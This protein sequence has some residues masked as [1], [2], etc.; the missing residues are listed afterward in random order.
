[1]I[2]CAN[3][4][5]Q[6]LA[7]KEEIDEAVKRV[8]EGDRYILGDEVAE[9]EK[10]F[11]A[12]IETKTCIGVANGTDALHLALRAVGVKY[13]DEVITTAHT[14]VA[15]ASAIVLAGAIP[16][17]ADIEEDYYTIDPAKVRE[18]ITPKTRAIIAVHIY[19]Q[20]CD[21]DALLTI[22]KE[23]N[24]PLIEDC[25][26]AHGAQYKGKKVGSIGDV[27]CFSF[28]PTKNLGAIGDGGAVATNNDE[29]AQKVR[30]LREYGWI[31][32]KISYTIGFN[33]RL[34]ELQAAVLRVK[35][36]YLQED[37]EKRREIAEHYNQTLA[38]V[39]QTP[40]IR[41]NC[42]HAYHL[43]VIQSKK[44]DVLIETLKKYAILPLIHYPI[45]VH[46][47]EGFNSFSPKNG[48]PI[49]EK[50][51]GCIVSLP[52]YP[53]LSFKERVYISDALNSQSS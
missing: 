44:R 9:F 43:Y 13:G 31:G 2:L 22:A 47:Q 26:Q 5:L 27:S 3:P 14:A 51:V 17:F 48:L 33:S 38:N 4:K 36:R 39:A 6:Y 52:M 37:T 8:L 20:P 1:M 32:D 18:A 34:D 30:A 21:M 10:E 40:K 28:Y 7:H 42:Q 35:L 24:I 50:L 15:T 41:E 11:A 53:E 16:V 19:G 23:Y 45:P 29:I 46:L 49:T 12:F 25:A